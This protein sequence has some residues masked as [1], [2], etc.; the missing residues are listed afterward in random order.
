MKQLHL[1]LGDTENRVVNLYPSVTDQTFLGFGGAIT[2]AAAVTYAQMSEAQKTELL[3]A[4]FAPD[5]MNYQFVRIPIDSCDFSIGEYCG[6]TESGE[7]DFSRM[8]QAI[9]P[10]LR[11]AERVAGRKIPVMLS[12]WSPPAFM[13]SNGSRQHGGKLLPEYYGAWADYLCRYVA[14]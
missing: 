13:K 14:F 3:S 7:P 11:D 2:E 4:Y 1:Q 5:R 8:E 6:Y 10:M 12:P 9:L